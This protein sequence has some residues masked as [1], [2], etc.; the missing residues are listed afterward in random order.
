MTGKTEANTKKTNVY[1]T[2]YEDMEG[3]NHAS[4]GRI[5]SPDKTAHGKITDS[6]YCRPGVHEMKKWEWTCGNESD[7]DEQPVRG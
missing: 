1:R 4:G 2:R 7:S 3:K 5:W 6:G